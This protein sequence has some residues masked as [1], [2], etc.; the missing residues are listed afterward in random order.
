MNYDSTLSQN[1]G[2]FFDEY[3]TTSTSS[4]KGKNLG[5]YSGTTNFNEYQTSEFEGIGSAMTS[6]VDNLFPSTETYLNDPVIDTNLENLDLFGT[7]T[8]TTTYENNTSTKVDDFTSSF[9]LNDYNATNDYNTYQATD[10]I[11]NTFTSSNTEFSTSNPTYDNIISDIDIYNTSQPTDGTTFNI[12]TKDYFTE[13]FPKPET[14]TK[15]NQAIKPAS[16]ITSFIDTTSYTNSDAIFSTPDIDVTTFQTNGTT[17]DKTTNFDFNTFGTTSQMIDSI[18][19]FNTDIYT[20]INSNEYLFNETSN[21]NK[22]SFVKETSSNK[23]APAP[24]YDNVFSTESIIDL[25]PTYDSTTGFIDTNNYD[26]NYNQNIPFSTTEY[27]T[28]NPS[29]DTTDYTTALDDNY[30]FGTTD[31]KATSPVVKTE[32]KTNYHSSDFTTSPVV[33]TNSALLSTSLYETSTPFFDTPGLDFTTDNYDSYLFSTPQSSTISET[34]NYPSLSSSVEFSTYNKT[35][36]S[37]KQTTLDTS[38]MFGEYK[39]TTNIVKRRHVKPAPLQVLLPPEKITVKIPKVK[40]VIIPKIKKVYIPTKT[41]IYIKNPSTTTSTYIIENKSSSGNNISYVPELPIH[42]NMSSILEPIPKKKTSYSLIPNPIINTSTSISMV[43]E[44]SSSISYVPDPLS[45]SLKKS[46]SMYSVV[47]QPVLSYKH[48]HH[49]IEPQIIPTTSIVTQTPKISI[50]SASK[51]AQPVF[52]NNISMVP[53][54]NNISMIPSIYGNSSV[55]NHISK[56]KLKSRNKNKIIYR[57]RFYTSKTYS[58]RK[59]DY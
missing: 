14:K 41:K 53:S 6:S 1:K 34:V 58:S 50:P 18:P 25:S 17:V 35:T 28:K 36:P 40:Q 8:T 29:F 9:P 37:K 20:N 2:T 43:P 46:K 48:K 15:T 21:K 3:K 47:P 27:T 30:L 38:A 7:T 11:L 51:L 31:F 39:K 42:K 49:G 24:K 57:P 45:K 52:E 54:L 22:S 10:P 4:S 13:N 44:I 55:S 26:V 12:D 16:D 33:D 56:E 32:T 23:K 59:F 19:A 5:T